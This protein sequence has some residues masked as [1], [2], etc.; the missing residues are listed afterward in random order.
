MVFDIFTLVEAIWLII[1]AY[2]ANG[3][4][5]LSKGMHPID[6]GKKFRGK[7]LFGPGK[8][9]EGLIF[10]TIVAILIAFIMAG[11]QNLLPWGLS[12]QP[13]NIVS[14]SAL[15]G[16]FLGL[17]SMIG[18][19]AGSFIKRRF[20]LKR[21]SAAP[22]LDQDDFIVG[23]LLF[24][25]IIIPIAWQWAVLLLIITPIFH[26]IANIIGYFCKIKNRP[27]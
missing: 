27:Y 6:G 14:M 20:A 23:S 1:P 24:A 18:D 2:A 25:A 4:A 10:G 5:P 21:G 26:L 8:T 13:L 11:A 3:L 22:I 9:W 17:G 7:E 16:L 12:P 19:V 15:L